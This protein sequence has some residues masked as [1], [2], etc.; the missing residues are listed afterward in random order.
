[1]PAVKTLA[2]SALVIGTAG[3]LAAG[4][5]MYSASIRWSGWNI[6]HAITPAYS[7]PTP[8]APV[9]QPL[10]IPN[11]LFGPENWAASSKWATV[12]NT[13]TILGAAS[14]QAAVNGV[15]PSGPTPSPSPF[16][17]VTTPL[18]TQS[19]QIG[20]IDPPIVQAAA[21]QTTYDAFVNLSNGKY[22]EAGDLTSGRLLPW[23]D[24]PTVQKLFGGTPT[25]AQQA[26]FTAKVL[27]DVQQ[28]YNLAHIPIHLTSDPNAQAAH[29]LSVVSGS[30][31][32]QNPNAVGLTD[33]G[34]SGY[35][36]IDKLG[37]VQST[38][39][40]ALVVGHN[41]AHELMHAFG[42]GGHPDTTGA[43]IDSGT[44]SWDLLSNPNAT[45]SPAAVQQ[46]LAKN[47]S[48]AAPSGVLGA[49]TT[50][51]HPIGCACPFCSGR[52]LGAQTVPEPATLALWTV[53]A[54]G[55]IVVRSRGSRRSGVEA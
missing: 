1:M 3:S 4:G 9:P 24:S 18:S 8:I 33:V 41:V 19:N 27:S 42:I 40:L 12:D 28:T 48:D 51:G 14:D 49:Q 54:C 22:A 43:F 55:V 20:R 23:Y 35:S 34:R 39:Q 32:D 36:F 52:L 21:P 50:A 13:A 2:L 10:S 38:D 53:L 7:A 26:D 15:S 31:S 5:P 46:L 45:F 30:P 29:I 47:F 11:N 17:N 25:A 6:R 16:M 37:N 44:A